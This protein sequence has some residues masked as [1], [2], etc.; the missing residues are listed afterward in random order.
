MYINS[1][2]M[3]CLKERYMI[4]QGP[5]AVLLMLKYLE[6]KLTG[7]RIRSILYTLLIYSFSF[8]AMSDQSK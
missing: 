5:D 1:R 8:S 4:L 6:K 3:S 2:F 7:R